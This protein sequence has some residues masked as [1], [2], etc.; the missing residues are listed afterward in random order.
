MSSSFGDLRVSS[1]CRPGVLSGG[2]EEG[3]WRLTSEKLMGSLGNAPGTLSSSPGLG[4]SMGTEPVE[5]RREL[6]RVGARGTVASTSFVC[7]GEAFLEL[8]EAIGVSCVM[9]LLL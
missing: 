2:S 7:V 6:Q 1:G 3:L 9:L 5:R 8:V 4:H